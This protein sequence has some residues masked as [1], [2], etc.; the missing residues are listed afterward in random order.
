[1]TSIVRLSKLSALAIFTAFIFP[2]SLVAFDQPTLTISTGNTTGVYYAAGSAVAKMH[3]QKSKEYNLRLIV[4]ASEGSIANIESVLN[5]STAFGISQSNKLYQAQKGTHEWDGQPH[6]NLRA[7]LGLYTEDYTVIA[8]ADAGIETLADLKGKTVNI[9][10]RGSSD[11]SQ[12]M[13]LFSYLGL[14]PQKDL[15]V[16][17]KPTYDASELLQ[18]GKID[19]YLYTVG[20]PN[21]SV[22]EVSTGKRKVVIISPGQGFI[23]YFTSLKPFVLATQIPVEYYPAI[24]NKEPIATIGFKSILFTSKG[25]DEQIVYN[26]VKE[27]FA[28]LDLF[29]RQQLAFAKLTPEK[30]SSKLIVPVHPGAQRYFREAGLLE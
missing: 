4:E 5:G 7:V 12:A 3:N 25:A 1:M 6:D 16:V 29:K 27:V 23:D 24:G 11:A 18:K 15:T 17:E 22:K 9:G 14:D 8:A 30:L 10:E 19:A 2:S 20:H 13:A 28:N 21:L 26:M